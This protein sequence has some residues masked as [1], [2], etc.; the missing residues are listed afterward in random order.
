MVLAHHLK[1]IRSADQILVFNQGEIVERG[2]HDELLEKGGLYK[3]LWD[4]Q[5]RAKT[6]KVGA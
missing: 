4:A 3:A 5:E 6:W 1:T 2:R